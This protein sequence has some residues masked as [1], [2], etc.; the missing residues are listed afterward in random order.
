MS[1]ALTED[2]IEHV[3]EQEMNRL[4]KRLMNGTLSQVDYER[5]V[6]DLD[7]WANTQLINLSKQVLTATQQ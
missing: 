2:Q 5:A 4:D 1:N 7:E 3:V 6:H